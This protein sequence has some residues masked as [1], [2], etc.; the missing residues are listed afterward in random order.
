[1]VAHKSFI[2]QNQFGLICFVLCKK[3]CCNIIFGYAD[4]IYDQFF[5]LH[6][7]VYSKP[8]LT[9]STGGTLYIY[10]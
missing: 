5:S 1:M 9:V 7:H 2:A 4:G 10:L 3:H 8:L 6:Q